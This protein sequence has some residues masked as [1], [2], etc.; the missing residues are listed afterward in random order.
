[1]AAHSIVA[2]LWM[3]VMLA[4][5][6][7]VVAPLAARPV[8]AGDS[9]R[10]LAARVPSEVA[11]AGETPRE[12][13]L[14]QR[15][16]RDRLASELPPAA[17]TAR[18]RVQLEPDERR[19]LNEMNATT[20]RLRVGAVKPVGIRVAFRDVDVARL[21]RVPRGAAGGT[22]RATDDGGFIWAVA[23]ES[24]EAAG[25]RVHITELNLPAAAA[26]YFFS[27]SGDAFGPY[28][29]REAEGGGEIWSNTIMDNV[30]FLV[31]RHDGPNGAA[32]LAKTSFVLA[33]VGHIGP[34]FLAQLAPAP[35]SFCENHAACVENA[36]CH[37]QTPAD[38]AK[39]AV[40]L[41]QWVSGA[42]LYSCSG[43]LVADSDPGS[44]IPYFLSANHCVSG[45]SEAESLECFFQYQADCGVTMCP[46]KTGFPRTLGATVRRTNP[47]CDY[48]LL[49]LHQSPPA[50]SVFLG[51][52]SEPVAFTEGAELY[53]ISH[54]LASPQAFSV[55]RVDT[56]AATC[57]GW[58]R[59][60]WIYSRDTVGATQGGS[61]GSPVVNGA[62]EVVGQFS[63]ACGFNVGD[64]MT[65][66]ACRHGSAG[67]SA[68]PA[69][70]LAMR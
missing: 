18:V 43:G 22:L 57:T 27:A 53:R 14:R 28:T 16:L 4:S 64:G 25:L 66:A 69:P 65:A 68:E 51:W 33:N 31:L 48:T 5:A 10:R 34:R 54:P 62:G 20:R 8:R 7:L 40:A 13:I 38:A 15:Q 45:Q 32:D 26:L 60:P 50:G 61:S 11:T 56:S 17:V 47:N 42:F 23:V 37:E 35:E 24:E 55:H 59:G 1:M 21:S 49:Q 44:Q 67:P 36:A 12:A 6:W 19:E 29:A 41:M 9:A 70:R 58:P 52:N 63:G 3:A 2:K 39:S 46:S 30:A